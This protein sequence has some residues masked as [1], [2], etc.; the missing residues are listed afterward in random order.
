M[1]L[2]F[3]TFVVHQSLIIVLGLL[4]AEIAGHGVHGDER[5]VEPFI[6]ASQRLTQG[7]VLLNN[8][9]RG[10]G[11]RQYCGSSNRAE[12]ITLTEPIVLLRCA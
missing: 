11:L 3:R 6:Q 7:F 4:D 5:F 12:H 8:D 1:P 10:L 2:V 9:S